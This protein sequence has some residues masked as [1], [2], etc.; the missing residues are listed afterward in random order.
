MKANFDQMTR[1]ELR[2]YVLEHRDD[3]EAIRAYLVVVVPMRLLTI[4]P[5]EP[6]K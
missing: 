4:P 1:E 2:A 5:K 3:G 6:R